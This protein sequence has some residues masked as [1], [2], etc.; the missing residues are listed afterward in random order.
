MSDNRRQEAD[1]R[2]VR[3]AFKL[4]AVRV[5]FK[6]E[7]VRVAFKL[8]AGTGSTFLTCKFAGPE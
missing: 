3:V 4:E 5:A 1:G 8:E 2:A 7:A 6:L